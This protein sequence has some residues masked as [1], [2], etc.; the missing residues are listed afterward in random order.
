MRQL[1]KWDDFRRRRD[2]TFCTYL[3]TKRTAKSANVLVRYLRSFRVI[4]GL[5]KNY[6]H[7]KN[8]KNWH[9]R[10]NLSTKKIL[11]CTRRYLK[12]KYVTRC[13]N[14]VVGGAIRK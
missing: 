1:N 13:G 12:R 14:P 11:R 4:I 7:K 5:Y 6:S 10:A 9:K 2:E 3:R 8:L